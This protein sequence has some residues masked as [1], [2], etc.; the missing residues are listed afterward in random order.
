MKPPDEPA[1]IGRAAGSSGGGG[2]ARWRE[3]AVAQS[4]S[5][6]RLEHDASSHLTPSTS[7]LL[8][9][10]GALDAMGIRLGASDS[11]LQVPVSRVFRPFGHDSPRHLDSSVFVHVSGSLSLAAAAEAAPAR[12]SGTGDDVAC[13]ALMMDRGSATVQCFG[14]RKH[15]RRTLVPSWPPAPSLVDRSMQVM[16]PAVAGRC[17][18]GR[19]QNPLPNEMDVDASATATDPGILDRRGTAPLAA[20]D[21]VPALSSR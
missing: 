1:T 11:R 5:V 18:H 21:A 15:R 20:P 12:T 7:V 10:P 17:S 3:R 19:E 6:S 13:S 16:P 2:G 8:Y 4:V 14:R 9:L